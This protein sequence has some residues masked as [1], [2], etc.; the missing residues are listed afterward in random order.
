MGEEISKNA[1]CIQDM[2]KIKVEPAL[3]NTTIPL[4]ECV[5]QFFK[6]AD[7]VKRE[8]EM[9]PT[10]VRWGVKIMC[11]ECGERRILWTDGEVEICQR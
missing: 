2:R 3:M 10:P 8:G 9:V 4:I 11:G 1:N 7:E 5:H 6:I